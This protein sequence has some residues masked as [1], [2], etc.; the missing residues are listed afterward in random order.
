MES[1]AVVSKL[2]MRPQVWLPPKDIASINGNYLTLTTLW[3]VWPL[4]ID[5][6][7]VNKHWSFKMTCRSNLTLNC[8]SDGKA[9]D[10]WPCP[11]GKVFTVRNK[12]TIFYAVCGYASL[13]PRDAQTTFLKLLK[14]YFP[15]GGVKKNFSA[16]TMGFKWPT[17]AW[18]LVQGWDSGLSW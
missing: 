1:N 18:Q 8:C 5:C 4:T 17:W 7:H 16:A 14:N 9:T 13:R 11:E 15:T 12:Q 3:F 6:A 2:K 10:L